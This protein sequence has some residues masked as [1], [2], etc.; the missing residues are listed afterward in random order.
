MIIKKNFYTSK[1]N[2]NTIVTY[3]F[4]TRKGGESK[5]K[6][7][8]LNCSLSSGDNKHLVKKNINTAKKNLNLYKKKMKTVNQIHSNKVVL[9]N[10]KN[11]NDQFEADGII[12]KDKNIC[13]GILTAD[14]CPIFF[15]DSDG[16]F[17]SCVH[18]G[19][20]GCYLNI[21][22]KA[23]NKI[24]KI[25]KD[26][27]KIKAIIGPCLAKKKFEVDLDFKLKFILKYKKYKKF[28]YK[29]NNN[30]N[31]VLF[32]MSDL[33][34]YQILENKVKNIE[35]YNLDTYSNKNLFYSHRRSSHLGENPS[36]RMIN[37]I[38]FNN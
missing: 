8:S 38:G 23:L 30:N 6:Y 24:K 1:K 4:F 11:I 21:I 20:K 28:F 15:F 2:L 35:H 33:I 12:T 36:G 9:I 25:Q 37:I 16:L 22:E 14:C 18:V 5:K 17:I 13:I 31:K 7:K 10:Q 26:T 32:D 34:K 3:G 29:I 27:K 19:W